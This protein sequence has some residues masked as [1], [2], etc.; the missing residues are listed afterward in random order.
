[1]TRYI[2]FKS[3]LLIG[4]I[5]CF[6]SC[7]NSSDFLD[8]ERTADLTEATVFADSART[9]D[10]LSNIYSKLKYE[11]GNSGLEMNTFGGSLSDMSDEAD[12][13]WP[14]G[15]NVGNQIISGTFSDAF[16]TRSADIWKYFYVS[17]RQVNIYIKD[18]Y[19]SPLSE[20]KIKRTVNEARF[21]RAY[22]YHKLMCY[23][24][25]VVLVG[26]DVYDI[27]SPNDAVRASYE[28]CVNYIVSEMDAIAPDLPLSYTGIEYGRVTRGAAL[29]LKA[30]VLLYAAS[31]LYN[32]GSLTD[33]PAISPLLAYPTAD[34]SRWQ[35]AFDAAQAVVNLNQY[36]LYT[37][38]TTRAGNGFY[39]LFLERVNP[40]YI[41][42]VMLDANKAIEN[43][44][45]PPSRGGQY[46]RF[47]TQEMVD[48]F[49]MKN[50][51]PISDRTSGYVESNM[52]ANRDPRFYYTVI[53]NEA[54][55]WDQRVNRMTPVYTY[56]GAT[57]DGLKP[58]SAN[59]GTVTGY[60]VR[61][62]ANESISASG[63][64]NTYRCPPIF[65]YAEILLNLAE[66]A[67][68]LGNTSLAMDQL[69][70]IRA[71]AGIEPGADGRY[72]IPANPDQDAARQLIRN[73]RFIELAFEDH[74]YWDL[75][76]WRLGDQYDGKY[77]HG[78][79]IIRNTN[80]TY[81]A[82]RFNVRAPRYFKTNS[83]FFP[84]PTTEIAVNRNIIQNP[85]W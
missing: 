5:A 12:T 19:K 65:R 13:R 17:I 74:R 16:Y 78:I 21:L 58:S 52:Y 70:T 32:G 50:G 14:G 80:G 72:G 27:S 56:S 61:K 62:M 33:D 79:N 76:R 25:G 44:T 11:V 40:E 1:M 42:A 30:R 35:K 64:G 6:F 18:V 54:Q 60:Y 69:I 8:P 36:S 47:P 46:Y 10:F 9:M 31:P 63:G 75:R 39:Q 37:D 71:R 26:D 3:G 68:E 4:L 41:L 51:K 85:G 84:I 28:D 2:T 66:A 67:N 77:V 38:N 49:P 20:A 23:F 73:E 82:S 48:A 57:L 15:H 43:N 55:Y 83:Y 59:T 53:Y 34:P 7:K 24:G 29:A 45:N 22:F 81:T